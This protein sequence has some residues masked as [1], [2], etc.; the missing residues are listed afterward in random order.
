MLLYST[1]AYGFN[2]KAYECVWFDE[3]SQCQN[4]KYYMPF[5]YATLFF[6]STLALFNFFMDWASN[7]VQVY[8]T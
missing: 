8:L 2:E 1:N 7:V 6:N 5:L 3:K 4:N